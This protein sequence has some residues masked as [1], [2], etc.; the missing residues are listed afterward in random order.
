M[1]SLE[2]KK[3]L[4][5]NQQKWGENNEKQ[6]DR[7]NTKL[8]IDKNPKNFLLL[9]CGQIF[10][11]RFVLTFGIHTQCLVDDGHAYKQNV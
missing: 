1:H 9:L 2:E 10:G 8:S 5:N 11:Q 4:I 7:Q 6:P 3:N